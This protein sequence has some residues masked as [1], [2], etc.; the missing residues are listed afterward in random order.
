[1]VLLLVSHGHSLNT[2]RLAKYAPTCGKIIT[3]AVLDK[4]GTSRLYEITGCQSIDAR[5]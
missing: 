2:M 1:M 5:S 3:H 4:Q